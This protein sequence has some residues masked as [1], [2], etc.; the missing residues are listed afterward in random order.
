MTEI[1]DAGLDDAAAVARVHA[2]SWKATY[3]GILPDTYLDGEVDGERAR[4]WRSALAT[5]RYPI[6]KLAREAG[7]VVG[8]IALHDDPDDGGYDFTI[9]HLHLLP[10]SKGR[11][12]G[13][14]LMKEAAVAAQA[15]GAESI[16]LWVFE[17]NSAAI[18]FYERLGGVTDAHDTDKFAGGDAPDRRI[19]WHDLDGLI[20]RCGGR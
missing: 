6:V 9:E 17:D 7:A 13:R 18:G 15:Q 19:G 12:L 16:C 10:G 8:L 11:G 5:I 20:A 2:A 4:Y 14:R 1:F 3:R